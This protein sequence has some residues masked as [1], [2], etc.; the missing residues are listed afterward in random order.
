MSSNVADRVS[1]ALSIVLSAGLVSCAHP[2]VCTTLVPEPAADKDT[3]QVTFLGVAGSIIRW[4]GAAVMTA[5]LYSNPT[6]LEIALTEIHTDRQRIDSLLRQDLSGVRAILSGHGHY[7]HLM[8]VPYVALAPHGATRADIL[9]NDQMVKVLHSIR[10]DL[11]ARTPPNDLVSL[12]HATAPYRV[13]GT[14]IQI[15]AVLSEHAPQL[16]PRLVAKQLGLIGRL[17]DVPSVTL[18]RGEDDYDL[19]RPPTRAGA[20][21]LGTPLAYVIELLDPATQAVAFRIYFQ[22]TSTRPRYG[23]PEPAS[24]ANT[25]QLAML[26]VGGA[27][28]VKDFPRDIVQ[29]LDAR[30]V[31]GIHWDDFFNPRPLAVRTEVNRTERIK[32]L[33]GVSEDEFL[34]I[35]RGAQSAGGRAILPCPDQVMMFR[36][37]SG[38]WQVT[39]DDKDWTR[40]KR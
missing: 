22:D 15:K 20:W 12:E 29:Y 28:E 7:D 26:T 10:K 13:P 38:T 18:W 8:D 32:Y 35:A 14:E 19:D 27:S 30:F 40:P 2:K 25:Y 4:Q 34:K 21:P 31:M 17:M 16:G 37:V 23:Y 3:V 11:Q 36:K 24:A 9:G 33:P 6:M 1:V 39:G 5:P